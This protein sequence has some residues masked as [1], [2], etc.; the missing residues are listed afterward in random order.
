[1]SKKVISEVLR[2]HKK[3]C[4]T[5]LSEKYVLASIEELNPIEYNTFPNFKSVP[6][7]TES[8]K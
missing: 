3:G 2:K 5:E 4:Q 6:H 1:M 7:S 8:K